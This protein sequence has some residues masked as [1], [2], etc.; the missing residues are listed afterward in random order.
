MVESPR[1]SAVGC[2]A[3]LDGPGIDGGDSEQPVRVASRII[4][5]WRSV[6]NNLDLYF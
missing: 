2:D 1:T 3:A 6:L 4:A 5:K